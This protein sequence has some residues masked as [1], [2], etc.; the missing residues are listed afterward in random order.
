MTQTSAPKIRDYLLGRLTA[1]E[2]AS[3][4]ERYFA[5]PDCVAEVWA[6]F[7]EL[8]EQYLGGELAETERSQFENRLRRSPAMRE[9]F[10][11]EKA[12]F[13]YA[14]VA[15]PEAVRMETSLA[16]ESSPPRSRWFG[17][18]VWRGNRAF[19]F[20]A[21]AAAS[22]LF[23]AG[24]WIVWQAKKTPPTNSDQ[25]AA[26]RED[27]TA[28]KPTPQPSLHP[29]PPTQPPA[30]TPNGNQAT[31]ATFFLPAQGFR[32][33]AEVPA[34]TIPNE[35]RTVR[36]E[37]ELASSDAARYSAALQSESNETIRKWEAL[38]PRR[39]Q[40]FN[41]I[42]LQL[43]AALLTDASYVLKVSSVAMANREAFTQQYRFTVK[44]R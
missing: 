34:L 30:T 15:L 33:G 20:A 39:S 11:N 16:S 40:P 2:E 12:L 9:M 18:I 10:E 41:R 1:E 19:K 8:S 38:S 4:E 17:P 14:H 29:P 7:A 37:L 21:L 42:V 31:I 26:L 6:V 43:P 23:V 25:L 13:R 32:S 22:A 3:L 28:N 5:D 36:L 35:A 44:R 27:D 24:S